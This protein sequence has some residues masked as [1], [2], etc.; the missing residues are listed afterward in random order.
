MQDVH[1]LCELGYIEDLIRPA[2]IADS[3]FLHAGPTA[4]I[5]FQSSGSFPLLDFEQLKSSCFLN[6]LRQRTKILS[7]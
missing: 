7:G 4:G 6:G 5:G 1:R 2:F 3:D